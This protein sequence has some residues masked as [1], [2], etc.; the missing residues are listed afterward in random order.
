MY[1][2]QISSQNTKS[3]SHFLPGES[4]STKCR[5]V[6]DYNN[7]KRYS[8]PS[9]DHGTNVWLMSMVG[10]LR[11][12]EGGLQGSGTSFIQIMSK[13]RE[14]VQKQNTGVSTGVWWVII[15]S[16]GEDHTDLLFSSDWRVSVTW[17]TRWYLADDRVESVLC[18]VNLIIFKVITTYFNSTWNTQSSHKNTYEAKC[19]RRNSEGLVNNTNVPGW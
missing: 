9:G 5:C 7:R 14:H 19:K 15:N 13:R 8:L 2:D 6:R 1:C 16:R 18:A 11:V 10:V 12:A 4:V 17:G 3:N